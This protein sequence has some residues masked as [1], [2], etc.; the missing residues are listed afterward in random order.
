[1][2]EH[3]TIIDLQKVSCDFRAGK[4][5]VRA[6]T[7]INLSIRSTDFVIVNGPSGCGKST[8]LN[9]IL[10]LEK[11]TKGEVTVREMNLFRANSDQ[12]ARFRASKIGMV[13]QM[14]YWIKSLNALENA[15]FPL[16]INGSKES[17]ALAHAKKLFVELG[18]AELAGQNPSHLSGGQQQRVAVARA[19]AVN[20]WII[21]ADEPTGNLDSKAGDELMNWFKKINRQHKRTIVL[22]TH[23]E[24][25]WSWGNRQVEMK[26]GRIVRDA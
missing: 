15:A 2:S 13:Y 9:V 5:T 23:N 18:I 8:L 16:I 22:V 4:N 20:P 24:A 26:D 6:L 7:N 1:M 11:P 14:F 25:Y 12:R 17:E 21:L 3:E 19:M 10:G